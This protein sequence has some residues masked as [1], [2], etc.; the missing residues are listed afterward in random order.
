MTG[1]GS[2]QVQAIGPGVLVLSHGHV[3]GNTGVVVGSEA[4][5]VVDTGPGP[6]HGALI[7][8]VLLELDVPCAGT[9][10]THGHWDHVLG[11]GF[12]ATTIAHA[13]AGDLMRAGLSNMSRITG[14]P[15]GE[16]EE[17]LP[18]PTT[19]VSERQSI[20]LGDR[21]VELMPTPGHSPDS[22]CVFVPDCGILFGGDT[23]VTC[24]PPVFRD[25]NS[26]Q[27]EATLATLTGQSGLSTIVPGHGSI[28]TEDGVS[29]ALEWPQWYIRSLRTAISQMAPASEEALFRS[30]TYDLYIGNRFNR[31]LYR[32]NW[33]HELTIRTLLAEADASPEVQPLDISANGR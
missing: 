28:A 7:R 20:D 11:G 19:H 2:F 14:R 15:K 10:L 3:E 33:R 13:R 12:G 4:A 32:M 16:I 9:I 5:V 22:I 25:G 8:S 23:V 18:W 31:R 27:L 26:R 30:L 24:I 6:D 29:D 1:C 21:S 17:S